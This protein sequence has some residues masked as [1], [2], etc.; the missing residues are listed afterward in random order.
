MSGYDYAI[1][2]QEEYLSVDLEIVMHVE[3]EI[4]WTCRE[5][6]K[7]EA[8]W[9]MEENWKS[10]EM[11]CS[12]EMYDTV[13]YSKLIWWLHKFVFPLLSIF[14]ILTR[15][16]KRIYWHVALMKSVTTVFGPMT[17]A[18]PNHYPSAEVENARIWCETSLTGNE[19]GVNQ[20]VS[21]SMGNCF[22]FL[23]LQVVH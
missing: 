5:G 21:H 23:T 7:G 9:R 11:F 16:T 14:W 2:M 22:R 8:E 19:F 20:F 1:S 17:G 10:Q 18:R 12:F 13:W 3:S 4:R 6:R 15:S